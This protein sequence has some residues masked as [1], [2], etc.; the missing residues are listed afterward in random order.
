MFLVDGQ[1]DTERKRFPRVRGDVPI[2]AYASIT[3]S[4]FS[5]RTRGCSVE[6]QHFCVFSSV[7]PAYAGMFRLER[8]R[9]KNQHCF[10]RVRG[11]VP[12]KGKLGLNLLPFSPRTRGCSVSKNPAHPL[13]HVFPAYA[14]MF[15]SYSCHGINSTRFPRVRGDVPLNRMRSPMRP[16]FS[17]RTRGCSGWK[18]EKLFPTHVFPA[19]AGMFLRLC[20]RPFPQ[21]GFPRVRGDVPCAKPYSHSGTQFS[22][23]TR[24]CS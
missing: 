22:P 9:S 21:S 2:E 17:P 10:P 1:K 4:V 8:R 7:F 13:W 14:G 16:K 6:N 11:D 3:P 15:L 5:P 24:G 12:T 18:P 23:R 19:Y 20:T